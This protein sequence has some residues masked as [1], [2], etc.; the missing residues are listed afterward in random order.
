MWTQEQL[1][2]LKAAYASGVREFTYGGKRTVYQSMAEMRTA[3]RDIEDGLARQESPAP[4]V[5][6]RPL[7]FGRD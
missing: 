3:I 2:A 6:T 5:M 1:A 4:R 7:T